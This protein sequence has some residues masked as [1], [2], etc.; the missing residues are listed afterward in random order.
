MTYLKENNDIGI[1]G[2][3]IL[4]GEALCL[5]HLRAAAAML[6]EGDRQHWKGL[7]AG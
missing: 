4:D 3:E 5:E 1:R 6:E 7:P 2:R